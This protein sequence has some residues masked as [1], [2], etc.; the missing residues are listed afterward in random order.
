MVVVV[1]GGVGGVGGYGGEFFHFLSRGCGPLRVVVLV[2]VL[3][4]V[5]VVVLVVVVPFHL[6]F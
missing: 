1:F 6:S 2:V 5:L 3:V 4:A